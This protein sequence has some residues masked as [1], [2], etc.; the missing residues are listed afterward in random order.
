[1]YKCQQVRQILLVNDSGKNHCNVFLQKQCTVFSPTDGLYVDGTFKSAPKFFHQLFTIHGLTM[2]NLHFSYRPINIQRPIRIISHTV[3][4]A[5]ELGVK[6]FPTIAYADL[7]TAIHNAV[8]TVWP[9][10]EVKAC[11]FHLGQSWWWKI[12]SLGLSK[13]YGEKDSEASQFLKKIFGLSLWP[14]AKSATA[15]RWNVY[16][17][18]RTSEWNCFATTCQKIILMQTPL[19]VRM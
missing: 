10:C 6:V 18:F 4:E 19:L 14:P 3:S 5:A 13:Q 11:R 12:Q 16:P 8:T 15:L 1:M 17:I 9:G 2:C 7:E